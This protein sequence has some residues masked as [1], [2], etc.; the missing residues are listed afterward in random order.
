MSAWPH[1]TP[2]YPCPVCQK[3]DWCQFGD[4]AIKCMR[5][6]SQFP[7]KSGGWYHPY[8]EK[9]TKDMLPESKP[10]KVTISAG[11]MVDAW[12]NQTSEFKYTMCAQ[13]LGVTVQSLRYLDAAWAAQYQAMAFPMSDETESRIGIRLR[14]DQGFKWA[15]RGSRQG[16]FLPTCETESIA[17]LPEGPTDTAAL[18][19]LG[20]YAIGRP[21]CMSGN[22]IL[23]SLL[24]KKRIYRAVIVADNDPPNERDEKRPGLEG[25]RKLRREL[26]LA[27]V[28]WMPPSPCKD[29]RDYVRCGGTREMIES[30]L[31]QKVWT[32]G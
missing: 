15:V 29:V 13:L 20:Y 32:K 27:S 1:V 6:T 21:N 30:D 10:E 19:S 9:F 23:H 8:D 18:L 11:A 24:R 28:I 2:Q 14:N 25:A 22:D 5:V 31:R 17:F 7:C 3:I 16:V 4:Y 26:G 12:I